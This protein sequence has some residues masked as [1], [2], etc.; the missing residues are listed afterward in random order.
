MAKVVFCSLG[1]ID[2]HTIG[3]PY[4]AFYYSNMP[5]RFLKGF[6]PYIFEFDSNI[7]KKICFRL[8]FWT[9]TTGPAKRCLEQ[10]TK[11]VW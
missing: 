6:G 10:R 2:S 4:R 9:S 7:F 1:I 11:L 5:P 8:I 3:M